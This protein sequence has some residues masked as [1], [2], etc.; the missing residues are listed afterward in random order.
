MRAFGVLIAALAALIGLWS[1]SVSAQ[2]YPAR[3]VHLIVPYPAGGGTD[4]FARLVGAKMSELIGQ[5]I[6]V[7]NKP[8]AATNLGAEFVAK[9]A[10]DGYTILLG[11]VA[12]Y[13]ANPSL[14]KKLPYDPEKDFAPISLTA[15]FLTVLVVNPTKLN[16]SSVAELIEAARKAPV[17]IDIAHAGVG[18]P[19][20]LAATLFEQ[21]A[22]IKLSQVPYRG[23]GPAVQAL[24]AGEVPLMFVDYAT[25]RA[26]LASGALKALAVAAK[27]TR[28]ELPGVPPVADAAGL[29]DF[30]AWPWQGFVAPAKTPA[31]VIAKLHD[32]YV[33]AVSDPVV[34]QKL[35]DA[36]TEP[37][38]SSP[39]EMADYRRREAA[40]WA[41]V[42]KAGNL[43]LD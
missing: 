36:G 40:K 43:Q 37:L 23:A 29:A 19:F 33:A 13:A 18:N 7:E 8:G 28:P 15:R 41:A 42:I 25:A 30:E 11:D 4:F 16:I 2:S 5:P 34:R 31:G 20:H 32:T 9:S 24:V 26:H 35:V 10:P 1:P 14:Y 22:G 38:Q 6:V 39:Q 12:T 27:T 3:P 21:A 17:S